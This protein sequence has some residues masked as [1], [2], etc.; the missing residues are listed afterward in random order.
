MSKIIVKFINI[1]DFLRSSEI[2]AFCLKYRRQLV[3]FLALQI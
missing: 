3:E 1:N 2:Y